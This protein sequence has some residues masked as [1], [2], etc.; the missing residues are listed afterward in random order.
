MIN[1]VLHGCAQLQS[2]KKEY[3]VPQE[4]SEFC[5]ESGRS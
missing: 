1:G 4:S 3:G 5:M 2:I